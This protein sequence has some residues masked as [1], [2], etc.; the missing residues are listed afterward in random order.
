LLRAFASEELL[1]RA[2]ARSESAGFLSHEFGD[3]WLIVPS[4]STLR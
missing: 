4:T 1:A 3:S 2:T